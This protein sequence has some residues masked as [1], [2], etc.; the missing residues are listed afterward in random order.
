MNST[1]RGQS[2][3]WWAMWQWKRKIMALYKKLR[4]Y[5][6]IKMLSKNLIQRRIYYKVCVITDMLVHE[7]T[8]SYVKE[9]NNL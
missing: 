9:Y 5:E 7:D 6:N 1:A 4:N 2:T 3:C 8:E